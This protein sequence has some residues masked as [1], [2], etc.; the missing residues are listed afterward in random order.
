[1]YC[2]YIICAVDFASAHKSAK[3]DTFTAIYMENLLI[4]NAPFFLPYI[5]IIIPLVWFAMLES[6]P[7]Y[8]YIYKL[9]SWSWY[10]KS[11]K[12]EP[13]I[14]SRNKRKAT[15]P[16]TVT[17]TTMTTGEK[18]KKESTKSIKQWNGGYWLQEHSNSRVSHRRSNSSDCFTGYKELSNLLQ[19][20][21]AQNSM[22]LHKSYE[23]CTCYMQ[24]KNTVCILL[25]SCRWWASANVKLI[26]DEVRKKPVNKKTVTTTA[27]N[28]NSTISHR[29]T[30]THTAR[31]ENNILCFRTRHIIDKTN[32]G[33]LFSNVLSRC[34]DGA[35]SNA[36]TY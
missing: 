36:G 7:V 8:R 23:L 2:T 28:N 30:H 34:F 33:I 5:I 19:L 27:N 9:K 31:K 35:I 16:T 18:Q 26:L 12:S 20:S 10:M 14:T 25:T 24:V 11:N 15:T 21:I 4:G 32:S 3:R 6:E 13:N 22:A 29:Q 1:M 17:T